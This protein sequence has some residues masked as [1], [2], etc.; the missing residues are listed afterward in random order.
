MNPV[1]F[2]ANPTSGNMTV[3]LT[4]KTLPA[5][6]VLLA[7]TNDAS[8][9][10]QMADNRAAYPDLALAEDLAEEGDWEAC[11]VECLR[12]EAMHPGLARTAQLREDAETALESGSRPGRSWLCWL[13]S[14]PI[15]ALVGF[16]RTVVAP[17]LGARCSLSP[18]CSEY[19]LRAARQRGWLGIPMTAD[20]LIR[21][22]SVVVAGE[23]PFRDPEGRK[24][25]PDPISDHIGGSRKPAATS[26]REHQHE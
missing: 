8:A 25:Y 21:E 23:N 12:V 19:S 6:L 13:G 11:H 26:R 20:R 17:A 16:Y 22:P 1:F 18:S 4:R 9:A 10:S 24:R 5:L 2:F 15:E 3:R 7:V 14:I